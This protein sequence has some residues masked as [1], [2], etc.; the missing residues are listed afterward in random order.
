MNG[1]AELGKLPAFVRRDMRIA[2]SYRTATV[3]GLLGS[4][5]QAVVFLF[6]GKLVDPSRL[7]QFGT[8]RATYLEFVTIGI[9]VNMIGYDYTNTPPAHA[10]G[11]RLLDRTP[12]GIEPTQ[13]GRAIIKRGVSMGVLD[14]GK[15][16][17]GRG[18]TRINADKSG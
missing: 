17:F 5:A 16:I 4:A 12:T 3:S 13:F 1:W 8:T 2:M 9:G 6:I 15:S 7:P 18:S 10:L 11:V 14:G